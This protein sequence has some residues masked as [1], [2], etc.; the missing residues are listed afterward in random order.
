MKLRVLLCGLAVL[1]TATAI[2]AWAGEIDLGLQEVIAERP[3]TDTLSTLIYLKPQVDIDLMNQDFNQ[4][5]TPL[6]TRHELVVN[7]LRNT[8]EA[9]QPSFRNHLE[10]LLR[11]GRIERF[12]AIWITNAF[13][14][15]AP[16]AELKLLVE[17][18]DVGTV[19]YNY[20]IQLIEPE[21]PEPGKLQP[22]A[23]LPT[24]PRSPELGVQA[25][26]APEVWARGYTG[27]GIL[28]STLDTGVDGNHPALAS[29]WRGVADSRYVDHPEWA[30]FDPVTSWTFPQDSGSHGTHTM[31]SV[32]GG[33]P[34]NEV[35][36][37]PGAQWIHAAVIDRVDLS[38]TVA[39]AILAFQWLI[40]PDGDPSTNWDVPAVCSNSWGIATWHSVAPYNEPCD[41]SFWS[42]LDACE[43]AGIVILFSAGNEG[44][45]SDTLRRPA[46]RAIDDYHT[47][48]VGGIDANSPPNWTMYSGSSRGP[49]LCTLTGEPAIKPD[50]AAPAVSVISSV[51]GGSYGP[52]TGTSMASP[53]VNGVVALIR[54]ACPDLTVQDVKQVMYE[55]AL[56]LGSTGKD[57]DYGYGLVDAYEAVLL[58]ESMCGLSPPRVFDAYYEVAVDT[59]ITIGLLASDFDGEPD[60]PGALTYQIRSLPSMELKDAG[61]QYVITPSDLPY[62]LVGGGTEVIYT[63]SGGHYGVETFVFG[64]SDGG[65]APD[66]GDS[67]DGTITVE[68]KYGPPVIVTSALPNGCVGQLYGPVA[69]EADQGQPELTWTTITDEY[70]EIDLGSSLFAEVGTAQGWHA[71]DSTWDY[72]LP[73]NFPFFGVNETVVTISSNGWLNFGSWTGSSYSNSE[74]SL[75]ENRRI[76]VLWDDLKT[77]DP[78]DIYIQHGLGFVTIRWEAIT[79]SGSNPV[80][81]SISLF[82]D[83]RIQFHYGD[84]NTPLT[85]TIGI[86]A[87]DGEHYLIASYS[88]E[89]TLTY[90]NSLEFVQPVPLPE[91][92]ELQSDGTITGTPTEFGTFEPRVKVTDSLNRI[93]VAQLLLVIDAECLYGL[94]DLNCDGQ[95]NSFD[96]DPFVLALN[97]AAGYAAQ[98]PDCDIILADCN[99]DGLVN[100]FDIDPFVALLVD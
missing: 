50:I 35:G 92:L 91:G 71:D 20:P 22:D 89:G 98:Y 87:G 9:T 37:A 11:A 45:S 1:V 74:E 27:Q 59:P 90:A 70:L 73:I 44:P 2:P 56:D 43:A 3:A 69:L 7:S 84:G 79:Y 99:Q 19:Y 12:D 80:N 86:S 15:D 46:D 5:R 78:H 26:R 81:A 17:H 63:P 13:R 94:G 75:I 31:G 32:C 95:V 82:P 52:K 85:N 100:A 33:A 6:N 34:G 72:T 23:P 36:V 60:P 8:A 4:T 39:D 47:C 49:T 14:V 77:T 76:A 96:I 48:A 55:T 38:T 97:N 41:P 93:D 40:D 58:A 24:G 16:A 21:T 83:G 28:V 66:G 18:P 68:T 42:Y 57:N 53:H 30:F 29:R 65:V 61:N 10:E 51:P 25:V 64:A 62:T 54:E 67:D 88:G